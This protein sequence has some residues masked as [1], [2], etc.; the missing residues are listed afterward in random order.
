MQSVFG[1]KSWSTLTTGLGTLGDALV[2][3]SGKVVNINLE[4]IT[5]S[6]SAAN[7][8]KMI[9]DTL[10]V[11]KDK[12]VEDICYNIGLM[13]GY[14]NT[15]GQNISSIDTEQMHNVS[16]KLRELGQVVNY[17]NSVNY[18]NLEGFGSAI[19]NFAKSGITKF[20]DF[21]STDH[22]TITEYGK[23][24]VKAMISGVTSMKTGSDK[25]ARDIITSFMNTMSNT[26]NATRGRVTSALTQALSSIC[27]QGANKV[28]SFNGIYYQA[29]RNL[30]LQLANGIRTTIGI[31]SS[32]VAAACSSAAITARGYYGS[33]YSAGV[34][35]ASGFAAGITANTYAA[36]ARAAAMASA[37][38]S[39]AR[40]ALQIASPS[41]VFYSIGNFAGMGLVNAL[42]D[43]SS[44]AFSAGE[45][46]AKSSMEGVQGLG[47]LLA[48]IIAEDVDVA[49]TITP[50]IDLTNVTSGLATMDSMFGT[51]QISLNSDTSN[52]LGSGIQT[53]NQNGITIGKVGDNSDVVSSIR[54]LTDRVD[55][56]GA[57]MTRMQ[58]VLDTGATVGAIAP[59]M[60][61]QLGRMEAYKERGI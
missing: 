26:I 28:R 41:K 40:R 45:Q 52:R 22:A 16:E 19:K 58:V 15:Y 2:S 55:K 51:R 11:M 38:A 34:Y 25:S 6:V 60:D 8:I 21:T 33:F 5:N 17:I 44:K 49:P 32:A 18:D 57:S 42:I 46:M 3:Y 39:A 12:T 35:V 61:R 9:L 23:K 10:N 37:A 30:G 1:S 48:S 31:S 7:T 13:G 4:A 53:L 14:L 47:D 29:G 36:Q 59:S 54:N 43:W 24:I 27:T 56:L 20:V 50:V